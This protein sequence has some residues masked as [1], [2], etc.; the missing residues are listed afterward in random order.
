MASPPRVSAPVADEPSLITDAEF[1]A[2]MAALAPFE[3]APRIAAGVSGGADSMALALL[4][5]AWAR[6]RGGSLLALVVDHGLRQGS[7]QEAAETR[8]RLN[9]RGIAV[10][11]LT[12]AGLAHGPAL[13]ER[14]RAARFDALEGAC[15]AAGIRPPAA[16]P[17]RRRSGRDGADPVRWAAAELRVSPGWPRRLRR[18]GCVFC[19]HCLRCLRP[20]CGR[21]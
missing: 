9:A 7:G 8:V 4:A 16:R 10:R 21:R 3:P 13:A 18:G 1:A 19:G 5:D 11:L 15:A 17:S 2:V 6:E 20:G 14:A 12:I